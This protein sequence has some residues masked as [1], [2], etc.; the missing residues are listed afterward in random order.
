[1]LIYLRTYKLLAGG[2]HTLVVFQ[3][4]DMDPTIAIHDKNQFRQETQIELFSRHQ[5]MI[6]DHIPRHAGHIRVESQLVND[7]NSL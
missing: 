7:D 2:I 4:M 1:M 5:L 6:D 3:V